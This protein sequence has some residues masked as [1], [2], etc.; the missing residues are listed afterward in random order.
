MFTSQAD[1]VSSVLL[2]RVQV[3]VMN[4]SQSQLPRRFLAVPYATHP[5]NPST[6]LCGPRTS[7][8]IDSLHR[9]F[10]LVQTIAFLLS[11]P[12]SSSLLL[13][14]HSPCP[15]LAPSSP[16]SPSS[17]PLPSLF[18]HSPCPL[19][20]LSPPSPPV[21]SCLGSQMQTMMYDQKQRKRL[22]LCRYGDWS[23]SIHKTVGG[24]QWI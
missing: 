5:V 19:L 11:S 1:P 24:E 23:E 2:C 14:P 6:A 21:A 9:T 3:S 10:V 17:L 4:A 13:S 18:P 12:S 15:L 20:A 22:F 7:S 8:G 16:F